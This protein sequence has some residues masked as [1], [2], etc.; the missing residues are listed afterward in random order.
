MFVCAQ[1]EKLWL[2]IC[3]IARQE[4][5]S[6]SSAAEK[7]ASKAREGEASLKTCATLFRCQVPR[8]SGAALAIVTRTRGNQLGW[9]QEGNHLWH[10]VTSHICCLGRR[11]LRNPDEPLFSRRFPLYFTACLVKPHFTQL[12]VLLNRHKEKGDEILTTWFIRTTGNWNMHF[13][14]SVNEFGY[15]IGD[16]CGQS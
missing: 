6:R 5:A 14:V 2:V 10:I 15:W 12:T 7:R 3:G 1:D 4:E 9:D 11:S 8:Y 13:L 16:L